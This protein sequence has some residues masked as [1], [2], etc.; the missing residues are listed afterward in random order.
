LH[1]VHLVEIVVFSQRTHFGSVFTGSI[2]F[3]DVAVVRVGGVGVGRS[4]RTRTGAV[5]VVGG[6]VVLFVVVGFNVTLTSPFT[7]IKNSIHR[8]L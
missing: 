6:G 1:S 4:G 8:N 5:V 7:T 2:L 3:R